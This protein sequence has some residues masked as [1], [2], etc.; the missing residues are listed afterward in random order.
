[1]SDNQLCIMDHDPAKRAL[2]GIDVCAWH[3]Q[4][5]GQAIAELPGQYDNLARRLVSTGT[6]LTGMPTGTRDP[7]ITIDPRVSQLRTDIHNTLTTW[8]RIAVEERD[9]STP[10][11]TV[12]ALAVYLLHHLDWYLHHPGSRQFVIDMLNNRDDA[13]RL[14]DPNRVRSFEVGRCPEPDCNGTLIAR[15]RPL[16][17]LLPHD[18]TCD[19]SPLDDD[20]VPIHYWPADKWLTMGRRIRRADPA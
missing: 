7:G 3:R 13:R 6:A 15:L 14:I 4:R 10:S 11:D 20:D 8:V 17:K 1:V 2:D 12:P 18:V 16:D 19:T 9:T 5:V